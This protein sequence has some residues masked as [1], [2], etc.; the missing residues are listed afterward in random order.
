M[1]VTYLY[2]I[3]GW[4]LHDIGLWL[5]DALRPAGI[6]VECIESDAWHAQPRETDTL[7]LSYSGLA[8]P[9]FDYRRWCSRLV[10]TVHDPAEVSHFEDRADWMRWPMRPLPLHLFDDVSAISDEL[11]TV[12]RTQYDTPVLRTAT[13]P[14]RAAVIRSRGAARV[15]SPELRVFSSTNAEATFSRWNMRRRLRRIPS[16]LHDQRGALSMRQLLAVAVRR[17]RKNIPLLRRVGRAV[18]AIPGARAD[19]AIGPGAVMSRDAYED[20][21]LGATVYL[22]TSTME[23]GPLPVMEAVLAGAAVV[24]TPVGQVAEWVEEG[25][26]GRICGGYREFVLAMQDYARRPSVLVA[27]Q[28]ASMEI[29]ASRHPP[30]LEPWVRLV[31]GG[32]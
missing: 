18:E 9:A 3:E 16:Y 27:H 25:R 26:N 2:N 1:R 29:A 23:G 7:Y 5:A 8:V 19:L 21:L 4:A 14:S 24:S 17:R 6:D 11:V 31:T 10:M 22:C 20:A 15:P 30:D 13:W 12:F 28:R 32:R